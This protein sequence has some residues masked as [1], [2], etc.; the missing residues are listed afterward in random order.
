MDRRRF[1]ES[2]VAGTAGLSLIG[3]QALSSAAGANI[4]KATDLVALGKTGVKM[5]PIAMGTG[6]VGYK[7]SSNQTRAGQESF[8]RLTRAYLDAGLNF[9]DTADLYG[10]M[11]FFKIALEG[12][13]RD[14]VVIMSKVWGDDGKQAQADLER[15]L[16]ELGTDYIDIVLTH[17][18]T[19]ADWY[20]KRAGVRETLSKAKEK[21]MIR[22][23]GVSWHGMAPLL[24]MPDAEWGDLFLVRINHKGVK[25]D[26]ERPQEVE[27]ILKKLH[28]K[29]KFVMAM[30]VIGE[31][32]IKD[33][34]E[35]DA[36]VR[37]VLGLGTIDAMTIGF[38]KPEQI[39]DFVRRWEAAMADV[40]KG[41]A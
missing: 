3:S 10:S 29:G 32:T 8:N 30:K 6:T 35:I 21:G 11:P 34:A 9:L 5:T 20:S 39:G 19:T 38:E 15:F 13:P 25:M 33:S 28:D 2:A 40:K 18:A 36:S 7:K 14:K 12:V 4:P 27:P 23:L 41:K 26:S 24:T 22:A 17:C 16:K 1:L 31:G 37:Y